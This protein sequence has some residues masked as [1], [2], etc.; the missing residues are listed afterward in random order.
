MATPTITAKLILDTATG[1]VG[2]MMDT[3]NAAGGGP[4]GAG[5]KPVKIKGMGGLMKLLGRLV[6]IFEIVSVAA[7]SLMKMLSNIMKLLGLILKPIGDMLT[8]ALMPIL[9]MLKPIA[10]IMNILFRPYL[11]AALV[12]MKVGGKKMAEGDA[13]GAAEAFGL[14][15]TTVLKPVFDLLMV[16]LSNLAQVALSV[17]QV[18]LTPFVAI[19]AQ[20]MEMFTGT[21]AEQIFASF[22]D[23]FNQARESV[24]GF[25]S[26]IIDVTNVLLFD[27]ISELAGEAGIEVSD[28]TEGVTISFATLNADNTKIM[29][30]TVTTVTTKIGVIAGLNETMI[31]TFRKDLEAL[32]KEQVDPLTESINGDGKKGGL[33]GAM[34]NARTMVEDLTTSLTA[35]TDKAASMM[36]KLKKYTS[37][38]ARSVLRAGATMLGGPVLGPLMSMAIEDGIITKDGKVI[39]VDPQDDIMASKNGFKGMGGGSV[40][41]NVSVN[42][43]DSASISDQFVRKLTQQITENMKRELQGRSSYGVGI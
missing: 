43:I 29:N 39:K 32:R 25:F 5:G 27:K 10:K 8:I 31:E 41:V 18:A 30:H 21:P 20:I 19:L 22:Q 35:L 28:F 7:G 40:N 11:R 9:Y 1:G 37:I 4:G 15:L 17:V 2:G 38:G 13:G 3:A 26:D 12:A 36:E 6:A 42:A 16:Q 24:S 34:S 14:G 23:G 33:I